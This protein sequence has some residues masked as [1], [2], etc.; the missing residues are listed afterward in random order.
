LIG[1]GEIM[2]VMS[3]ILFFLLLAAPS[4][5]ILFTSNKHVKVEL[6]LPENI[7]L[8]NENIISFFLDPI[9]GIHINTTPLFE[10]VLEKKSQFEISGKPRFTKDENGYLDFDK[11]I[12]FTIKVKNGMKAGKQNLKGKLNYFYCSDKEGWCNRFSQPF[13]VSIVVTK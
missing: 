11:S 9:D 2:K 13:D 3:I 6:K 5:K 8:S 12:D 4:E 10:I 1:F 7:S